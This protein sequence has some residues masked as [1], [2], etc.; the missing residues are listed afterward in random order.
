[1]R[2]PNLN[3]KNKAANTAIKFIKE[4]KKTKWINTLCKRNV[5]KKAKIITV[6]SPDNL[7]K[8]GISSKGTIL[9]IITKVKTKEIIGK[10]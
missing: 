10:K 1:M 3:T 6:K 4:P 8:P 2:N 5:A 9:L 7:S